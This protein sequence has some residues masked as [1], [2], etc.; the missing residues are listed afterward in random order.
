M[1]DV[2]GGGG[3]AAGQIG[4]LHLAGAHSVHGRSRDIYRGE[5]F[6]APDRSC[7]A[8]VFARM[9]SI[10]SPVRECPALQ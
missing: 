2:D 4:A 5:C 10:V 1:G 9:W 6:Y 3:L 8:E 7:F